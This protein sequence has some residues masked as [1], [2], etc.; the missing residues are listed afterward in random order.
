M[1]LAALVP[2]RHTSERVP[3]KNYRYMAGKPLYAYIIDTLLDCKEIEAVV[4]DTDSPIILQ[5]L[6]ESYPQVRTLERPEHLRDGSIPMNEII[7]YDLTQIKADFYLQTHSTNPL[8]TA[9]TLRKAIQEFFEAFPSK[10]SLFSV[11]RLQTRLWSEDGQPVNHDPSEL[12]RTQDLAPVFEENSCIYIFSRQVF[13]DRNHRLGLRPLMYEI[14]RQE[15]LDIDEELDFL[16]AEDLI[17]RR[18]KLD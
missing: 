16:I 4:V 8:L 14:D 7:K 1:R 9:P 15:S 13:L 3:G 6:H 5:G 12:I 17:H 11:T 10:D 18:Q 2:M